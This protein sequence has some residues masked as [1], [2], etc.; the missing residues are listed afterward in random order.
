MHS[1]QWSRIPLPMQE[2]HEMQFDPRLRRSP[3]ERNGNPFQCS[4]LENFVD[5]GAWQPTV[6]RATKSQTWW[7]DWVHMHGLSCSAACGIFPDQ[8][9]NPSL[10]HWQADSL[11]LSL[12]GSPYLPFLNIRFYRVKHTPLLCME[13]PES[14]MGLKPEWNKSFNVSKL[15]LYDFNDVLVL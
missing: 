4:C 9:S 2:S 10:L 1:S 15:L 8:R 11:P 13:T 12:L 5:R 6:H 3:G 14:Y 7:S